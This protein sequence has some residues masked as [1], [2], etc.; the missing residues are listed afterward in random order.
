MR[1]TFIITAA[2]VAGG[3]KNVQIYTIGQAKNMSSG[4]KHGVDVAPG[5]ENTVYK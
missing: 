1:G 5:N 4:R 2:T 3:R